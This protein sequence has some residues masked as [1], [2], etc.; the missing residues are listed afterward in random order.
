MTGEAPL[1]AEGHAQLGVAAGDPA[2]R[3]EG[4]WNHGGSMTR[5]TSLT[6]ELD[7]ALANWP[8]LGYSGLTCGHYDRRRPGCRNLAC[9]KPEALFTEDRARLLTPNSRAVIAAVARLLTPCRATLRAGASSP[10]SYELKH[11]AER[12]LKD[13]PHARGYVAN[14]QLIAAALLCGFPVMRER[15]GSPNAAVGIR[16]VDARALRAAGDGPR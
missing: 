4:I 12:L 2:R 14:G 8:D 13:D 5:K 3:V 16:R 11:T 9:G 6:A 7:A 1:T 10:G 15:D